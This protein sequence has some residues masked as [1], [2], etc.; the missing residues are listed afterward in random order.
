MV[1][2]KKRT[3][4]TG[5]GLDSALIAQAN[6]LKNNLTPKEQ[7]ERFGFVLLHQ[8]VKKLNL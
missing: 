5:Q 7:E 8:M 2:K 6:W 1:L 3:G 4:F